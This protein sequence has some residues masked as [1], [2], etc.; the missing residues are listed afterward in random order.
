MPARTSRERD[1]ANWL[2]H[3]AGAARRRTACALRLQAGGDHEVPA[4]GTDVLMHATVGRAF[5][6]PNASPV[7]R[8]R[9]ETVCRSRCAS[10]ASIPS[11][12]SG[13]HCE[14]YH[15]GG[16]A[17]RPGA[18]PAEP[19]QGL[20]GRI[21]DLPPLLRPRR[22]RL[23][24]HAHQRR[25]TGWRARCW[26]R[27]WATSITVE[28]LL[29][30]PVIKDLVVDMEPFF[31]H[32]RSVMPYLVNDEPP[33]AR[34]R[35]Q[36]AGPAPALRRHDQVHPVRRLHHLLPVV[37]GQR[38][39]RRAGGHRPGAPLHLR[40]PRPGRGASACRS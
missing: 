38:R 15:G 23:G 39:V 16:R 25:A 36:I 37:L 35:L 22:L 13:P 30:L 3:T 8:D 10:G 5:A 7:R 29:G 19:R 17:D 4:E 26:S 6:T 31:E 33:P 1:D 40:Q 21:A 20:P 9:Q 34:E 27:T 24:R 2:K 18:R 12:T 32:Y 28:P 14:S 11:R